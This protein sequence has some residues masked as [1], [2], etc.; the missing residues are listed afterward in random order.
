MKLNDVLVENVG[1]MV[2]YK[3]LSS[4]QIGLLKKIALGAFTADNV[5]DRNRDIVEQL[6]G[7]GLVDD[8]S[9]ELTEQGQ[10]VLD[11]AE[12]NGGSYQ[13]VASRAAAS[14]SAARRPSPDEFPDSGEID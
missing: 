2:A 3:Q 11:L 8:I 13:A 10:R 7:Y 12:R 5:N 9:F 6:F 14:A 4:L 1:S